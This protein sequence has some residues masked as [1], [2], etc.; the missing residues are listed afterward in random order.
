MHLL[1]QIWNQRRANLWIGLE[2]CLVT[3]LLWYAVDLLYNYEGAAHAPKGY[4][5]DC[6]FDVTIGCCPQ[7]SWEERTSPEARSQCAS[8][9][10]LAAAYPGVEAACYYEGSVPYSSE[11][12]YEG[13][14]AHTDSAHWVNCYIRYVSPSY[15]RVFRLHTQ[16]GKLDEE[17]W[18]A[19]E[20]PMPVLMSAALSDSLFHS[21]GEDAVG[22]TC[23]NPY[24]LN[25]KTP[26]TNYRL[27]AVLQQH[28]LDD[29][30]RY[31]PF[32]YLPAEETPIWWHH[33]ALRVNPDHVAGFA[34]RFR[35]DMQAAFA[36]GLFY[37]GSVTS[38]SDMKEAYDI[39]QG[40][41]NYLN[42]AYAV[43]AF[44]GFNIF[45]SMLGTFWFRTRKRRPEIALRM[46]MGCTRRGVMGYY[47]QEGLLLLLIA[48]LPALLICYHIRLA[49]LT[50]HTL[51]EP[52]AGRFLF[53]F[54]VAFLLLWL[55][56]ALGIWFPARQ[57]MK[58]QPAEAL[59]NE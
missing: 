43:I 49:D 58:V 36:S 9:Y 45:L 6:V 2:L 14:A 37:L 30:Q 17:H 52:T 28:K 56:I 33:I 3:V 54:A 31:E 5:T 46:A 39:E 38:Y 16:A 27:M 57:A 21:A 47:Q 26:Q 4:D 50:V 48:A 11:T 8:L 12:R 23:F 20:Y 35:H 59:H 13:Y 29:Y 18:R 15:F 10:R 24:W 1:R 32:I 51:M 55:V 40:T 7:S 25:T 44:F 34:E 22:R 19:S 53:C 41:V 42:T